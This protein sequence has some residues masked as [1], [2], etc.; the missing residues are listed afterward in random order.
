MSYLVLSDELGDLEEIVVG[1]DT[2]QRFTSRR[3]EA[4]EELAA[5]VVVL[6]QGLP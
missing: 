4:A 6:R 5:D 1:S 2:L 3:S